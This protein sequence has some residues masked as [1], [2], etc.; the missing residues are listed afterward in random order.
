MSDEHYRFL[1]LLGQ[2]PARP[3]E[4]Q[5]ALV[6]NCKPFDVRVIAGAG[7]LKPLGNPQPNSVKYFATIQ[8]LKHPRDPPSPRP[9]GGGRQIR[10][11]DGVNVK[12]CTIRMTTYA[13]GVRI[14]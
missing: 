3:K 9:S 14:E 4:E 8:V 11:V 12:H 13:A 7:L 10:Q 5:T 1:S 2:L 6:F